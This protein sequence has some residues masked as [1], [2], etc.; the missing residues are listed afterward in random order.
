MLNL[1]AKYTKQNHMKN[2]WL[3]DPTNLSKPRWIPITELNF[4]EH[5]L[6]MKDEV[7]GKMGACRPKADGKFEWEHKVNPTHYWSF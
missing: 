7:S 1:N 3:Y 2:S 6:F 4:Y 5:K